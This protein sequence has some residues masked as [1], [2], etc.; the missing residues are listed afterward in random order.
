MSGRAEDPRLLSVAEAIADGTRVDWNGLEQ[1][2]TREQSIVINELRALERFNAVNTD[3]RAEWG[4]FIITTEIGRGVF[5]RVY[6]AVDPNLQL[7]VALKVIRP[8]VAGEELDLDHALTEARLLAKV[9]HPNVVRVYRAER[10]GNEV[11]IAMELI[12]GQTLDELVQQRAPFGASEAMLIG[13]DLC[14]A[15]AAV[16]AAGLLHGDIKARNVMREAGGRTVL[17]D[18][19]AGRDLQRELQP[20]GDF[21]GTPV[22]L[23]PEVF[24][25]RARSK[26]SDIY[27][28]GVLLYYLVSGS[29]PVDGR[30]GTE[31]GR[32]HSEGTSRRPLRD[33]RPDL[34]DGFVRVVEQALAEKPQDRYPSAGAFETALARLLSPPAVSSRILSRMK[35]ALAA[36][37]VLIV[38]GL[39]ATMVYRIVN[40]AGTEIADSGGAATVAGTYQ[41]EAGLYIERD[42]ANLRAQ[43]G[44]RVAPGDKLS[45]RVQA[46]VPAH[47]YV[48]NEDEQGEAYL[49][50]PLP[51]QALTNP[52][53]A[54][55][56]HRLPG[57]QEGRPLS[58]QVTSAGGREH[59]L[60]FASPEPSEAFEQMVATLPP[61][62]PDKP[63]QAVRLSREAVGV[64]RGVGGLTSTPVQTSQQLRLTRDFAT[65]LVAGE[66]TVRGVWIRQLTLE[67]P[68]Q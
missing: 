50:F 39:G 1:S 19:G 25:G 64:L 54:E 56:P 51:G 63:V 30:T 62:T 46:S 52:L 22:Y 26:A 8:L 18:F 68:L 61:P 21:A 23:A 29:Y 65:P 12:K 57:V 48:V 38:V 33:A 3:T 44:M 14:R 24:A 31:I 66:E 6:H 17:M 55:Q 67:N 53:P 28:L 11:G 13:L 27:S 45:L 2:T 15:L 34:P 4:P 9:T 41:I 16:H 43:D 10:I 7:D 20:G 5:G 32:H 59:F 36:A 49:L 37:A 47:V 35:P 60:I 42:G 58:W 40:P